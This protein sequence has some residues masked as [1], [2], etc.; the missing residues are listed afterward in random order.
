MK[1][2]ISYLV[3]TCDEIV[4]MLESTSIVSNDKK[5]TDKPKLLVS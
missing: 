2:F 5:V 3:V 4:D 1:I